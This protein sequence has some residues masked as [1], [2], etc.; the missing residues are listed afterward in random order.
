MLW[1][2]RDRARRTA[3]GND[4]LEPGSPDGVGL[5][6]Y[7]GHG[8]SVAEYEDRLGRGPCSGIAGQNIRDK[9][10]AAHRQ[11][12]RAGPQRHRVVLLAELA[13]DVAQNPARRAHRQLAGAA[14][15]VIDE[16]ING[17]IGIR[18][19]RHG[20]LVNEQ[21]LGLAGFACGNALV[22]HDIL[23]DDEP[24]CRAARRRALRF[25]ID[26]A[27]DPDLL[28]RPAV[29]RTGRN[30]QPRQ[31]RDPQ[32]QRRKTGHPH[33]P[34]ARRVTFPGMVPATAQ[35]GRLPKNSASSTACH[36]T[37]LDH[38]R[39]FGR[40]GRR[41]HRRHSERRGIRRPAERSWRIPILCA[42]RG[43]LTFGASERQH[44]HRS[45]NW[46]GQSNE[47]ASC[48]GQL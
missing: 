47:D 12:G 14:L 38:R 23:A 36:V 33:S 25:G 7:R 1:R 20:R 16:L 17:Q 15:R 2:Y 45:A 46:S 39:R 29:N 42:M 28:L 11:R 22:E 30:Q 27:I 19:D 41:A 18:P 43:S 31:Q 5:A 44:R 34:E 4:D 48:D 21:Q 35:T 26:R 24:A 3:A 13:A 32:R 6:V 9:G 8:Q 40:C 10:A 37:A